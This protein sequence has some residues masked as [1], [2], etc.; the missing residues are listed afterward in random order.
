LDQA[1]SIGLSKRTS[2]EFEFH[3]R[4]DE[5][6]TSL[7][8]YFFQGGPGFRPKPW[9]LIVPIYRYQR[10]PADP[11]T[12]FEH[13]LLLNIT[14]GKTKGRLR[15]IVRTLWEGRFPANHDASARVRLRPGIEYDLPFHKKR[16][17][18]LVIN[19][20][21]FIVLGANS[22][23]AGSD[24]TQ[25]RFQAGVRI[26]ITD[27][28]AVRPYYLRQSVHPPSGWDSNG[29]IGLSLAFRFQ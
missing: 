4:F 17:P 15:P 9:L 24:F 3:Q 28:F 5:G 13:R 1:L 19:N 22:F 23:A 21:F 6:G 25:N 8:E 29:V 14:V 18:V 7:F 20:E 27:F 10:Y 12:P 11:Y 16:P 26:P 2:L